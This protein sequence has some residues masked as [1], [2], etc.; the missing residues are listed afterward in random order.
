[1]LE[2]IDKSSAKQAALKKLWLYEYVDRYLN[3]RASLRY[4][5]LTLGNGAFYLCRFAAFI[6]EPRP[7]ALSAIPRWAD[8]FAQQYQGPSS[9]FVVRSIL[10]SF[11]AFL[12]A[13]GVIAGADR[14]SPAPRRFASVTAYEGFLRE[15]CGVVDPT[16][17]MKK[18]YC[19]KFLAAMYERGIRKINRL[20]SK[21]IQ[22]FIMEEAKQRCRVTMI[23][24]CS[25]LRQF[26]SFLYASGRTRRDF[27]SVVITPQSYRHE[28]SPRFLTRNEIA[29]VLQSVDR[30]S[31]VGP[32]NYAILQ[33]L[34]TY[35]LRG[36]EVARLRLD[37]IEWRAEKI[38]F[39]SKKSDGHSV[40]PLAAAV[41]EALVAYL[42]TGRPPSN[43][44]EVFL[45]MLR[46]SAPCRPSR[47]ATSSRSTSAGRAWQPVVPAQH[48]PLLMRAAVV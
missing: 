19:T 5:R 38:H 2:L 35:G 34:A 36:I 30:Q 21:A 29:R 44:R 47:F 43:H 28:R 46:R 1:M 11:V 32:R 41:A 14:R 12:Q 25:I 13:D 24:Y 42:K 15:Q 23:S 37:D 26:L 48:V 16:V 45:P 10:N 31:S 39:H 20:P 6:N 40:Y 9:R 17:T 7:R 3:H 27:S 18:Q 8:S 33:L 22:D 4:A